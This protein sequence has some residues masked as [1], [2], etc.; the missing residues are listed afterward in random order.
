MTNPADRRCH[1]CA[2]WAANDGTVRRAPCVLL[3]SSDEDQMERPIARIV[4][5]MSSLPQRVANNV[6]LETPRDF[7]CRLHRFPNECGND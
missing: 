3:P 7:G 2:A 6:A 4:N 5:R 1:N